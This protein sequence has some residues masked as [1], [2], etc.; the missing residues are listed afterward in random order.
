[1]FAFFATVGSHII[2]VKDF[3]FLERYKG[4]TWAHILGTD[5]QGRDIFGLLVHGSRDV[6]TLGVTSAAFSILIGFVINPF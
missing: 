5:Y 3:G 4:P 6:L 2:P 1:M